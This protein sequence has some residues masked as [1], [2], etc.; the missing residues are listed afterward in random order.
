MSEHIEYC[1]EC[2]EPLG[3]CVCGK[4]HQENGG[5]ILT[6]DQLTILAI[7]GAISELPPHQEEACNELA[8]HFRRLIEAA[9][10][11]VGELAIALVGAEMQ[12]EI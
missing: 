1:D 8:E 7:K 11:P 3:D 10:S 9:G 6:E 4:P 5:T 2:D 12:A